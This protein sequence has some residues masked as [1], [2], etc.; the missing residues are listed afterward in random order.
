MHSVINK[1]KLIETFERLPQ[2]RQDEICDFIDYLA[3]KETFKKEEIPQTTTNEAAGCLH[4]SGKSKT[5]ED[6]DDAIREGVRRQWK[7]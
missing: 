2:N 6:I 5:Q 4:Y 7:K 1:K 3:Y